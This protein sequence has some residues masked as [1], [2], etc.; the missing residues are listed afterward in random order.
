VASALDVATLSAI[1]S[2]N[3]VT[4]LVVTYNVKRGDCRER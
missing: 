2:R 3:A 1:C 4:L